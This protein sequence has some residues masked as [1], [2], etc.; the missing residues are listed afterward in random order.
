MNDYERGLKDGQLGEYR[1]G[2]CGAVQ[3]KLWRVGASSC[4]RLRCAKC[5]RANGLTVDLRRSDQVGH[6]VPAVP[7]GFGN[8]WGYTSVPDEW[9]RWWKGLRT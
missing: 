9:V 8:W 3:R 6:W 7:D 1:C 5:L 4:I 2:N